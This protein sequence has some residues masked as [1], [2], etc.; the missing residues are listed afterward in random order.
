MRIGIGLGI[1][2][3]ARALGGMSPAT[4][5]G[6]TLEQWCRADSVT[7]ATGVSVFADLSGK[8]RPYLQ[9]TA[10]SQPAYQATGG[11]N[12]TPRLVGNTT[13]RIM[14]CAGY[15]PGPGLYMWAVISQLTWI[16]S[17]FLLGAAAGG[18]NQAVYQASVTPSLQGRTDA[19]FTPLN[20][21]GVLNQTF[22]IEAWWNN[23]A[24]D[25]LRIGATDAT[26]VATGALGAG[27]GRAI[28]GCNGGLFSNVALSE[29][30]YASALPDATKRADIAAYGVARYGV[31]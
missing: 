20:A 7:L 12:G 4:I 10:G 27:T 31:L 3:G 9:A 13:S 2:S 8:A 29:I 21:A 1:P 18:I 28:L 11:P 5:L 14:N 24:A 6:A 17:R 30:V 22:V 25:F 26:G 15:T 16:N 19:G 23:A